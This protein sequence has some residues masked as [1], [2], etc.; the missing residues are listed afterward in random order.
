MNKPENMPCGLAV[1]DLEQALTY[2]TEAFFS[3]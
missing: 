3:R 1:E 2:G